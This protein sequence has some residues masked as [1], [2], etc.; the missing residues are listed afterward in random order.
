ME[1]RDFLRAG[2]ATT[3]VA[4]L[5][6]PFGAHA[7]TRRH[8]LTAGKTD[9]PLLGPGAPS[10]ECWTFNGALPGPLLRF[11]KGDLAEIDVVNQ[12]DAGIAVHWHGLRVPFA[13]DGVPHLTQSPIAK[14]EKFRYQFEMNDSG[15]Y[16]YHAHA[17]SNDQV[18]RG[19]F[20]ALIVDEAS[21]PFVDRDIVWVL[22]DFKVDPKDGTHESFRSFKELSGDGRIGDVITVNGV[23]AGASELKVRPGERI[24]LRIINA[25]NARVFEVS[26]TGHEV[27][28]IALD[29]Q[30]V[31]PQQSAWGEM[32][33]APG[34]RTDLIIDC[35]SNC[36][37]IG[38]ESL[39]GMRFPVRDIESGVTIGDIVYQAGPPVRKKPLEAPLRLRAN[40]H[41]R[42]NLRRLQ[43]VSI[44]LEG[45]ALG[46]GITA[47]VDGKAL[48][49]QQLRRD[50][51]YS[52]SISGHAGSVDMHRQ[53]P[54]FELEEGKHYRWAI[55]NRSGYPHPMH[56]HGHRFRVLSYN[57][58]EPAYEEWR[59]TVLLRP[60]DEIE[61]AFVADNPGDWLFYC[62]ILEH[63]VSGMVGMVRVK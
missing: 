36:D 20:G 44:V 16:W 59:D 39:A 42:P 26:F 56:L 32:A 58:R 21:P 29:G 60:F 2:L 57:G 51:K 13:M 61:I 35:L 62:Q 14:G 41:K 43:P 27:W 31:P 54:L 37:L 10:S 33:I 4:L 28:L 23:R 53:Q 19:L 18:G 3:S 5:G 15:T 47:L 38:C 7:A 46:P 55:S 11:T 6:T 63:S 9:I 17:L 22:C 30:G 40:E 48:N 25:S 49:A 12:L 8:T 1:R 24:R 45:G 50:H 52:W 34:M